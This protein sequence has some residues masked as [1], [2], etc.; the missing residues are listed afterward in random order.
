VQEVF[1][2]FEEPWVLDAFPG[3]V[4]VES[5]RYAV[6]ETPGFGVEVRTDVL[7]QHPFEDKHLDLFVEGWERR[8]AGGRDTLDMKT[9][10]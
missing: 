4:V 7:E 6:S 9:P 1:D 5:G 8:E 3:R 10:T 2:D